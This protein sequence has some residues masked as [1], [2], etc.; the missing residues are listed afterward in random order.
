MLHKKRVNVFN[1]NELS[2]SNTVILFSKCIVVTRL[3][4]AG[5][6]KYSKA[7]SVLIRWDV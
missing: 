5:G 1:D 3:G 6:K 4:F 2:D 7:Q